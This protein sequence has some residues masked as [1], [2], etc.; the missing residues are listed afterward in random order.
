MGVAVGA[1]A[2]VGVGV[3]IVGVSPGA[4]VG[5]AVGGTAEVGVEVAA[6][7]D[8]GVGVASSAA[9]QATAVTIP[10]DARIPTRS[11]GLQRV[12][13]NIIG[14]LTGLVVFRV[15]YLYRKEIM[16]SRNR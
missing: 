7:R 6:G 16:K 13:S 8:V 5:V 9:P 1:A 3:A 10:T 14:L 15:A 2:L 12:L 4:R 11:P